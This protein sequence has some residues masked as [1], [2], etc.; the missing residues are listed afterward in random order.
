MYGPK[1]SVIVPVYNCEAYIERCLDSIVSQ[2]L[3]PIEI[4]VIDDGSTD[5]TGFIIDGFAQKYDNFVV[6]H[7]ENGG[8]SA[9]RN[10]GLALAK[11]EYIGFVD[12]DDYAKPEMFEQLYTA[13]EE[14]DADIAM[15]D[16]NKVYQS[17]VLYNVLKVPKQ[18][19]IIGEYESDEFY[20]KYILR[21]PELWN[22]IFKT[23]VV[24]SHNIS[25]KMDAGED[26]LFCI[27]IAAHIKK[28]TLISENL[29]NYV[30]RKSSI[31]HSGKA[32]NSL[33]S[34]MYQFVD[35]IQYKSTNFVTNSQMGY[36][37]IFATMFTGFMFS[38][39]CVHQP[40]MYFA[41]QIEIMR[42]WADFPQFCYQ[43]AKTDNLCD[44]Y[45]SGVMSIRFYSILKIIFSLCYKKKDNMAS[46]FMYLVSRLIYLKKR[47]ML[48]DL[49][50]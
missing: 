45:K 26:L 16:Y 41:K 29:Y 43:I 14:F 3:Q 22:K 31:V 50:E 21:S 36:H 18:N 4:I 19:I 10:K 17:K 38:P 11:G 7:Q 27:E 35:E 47:K 44:L 33:I 8:V 6:V 23:D 42:K 48:T 15:C 13:A 49:Y 30:Q 39:S 32:V 40:K 28:V 37:Y 20:L 25:F 5:R 2:T 1:V 12:A 34:L 9:A 24:H 46:F